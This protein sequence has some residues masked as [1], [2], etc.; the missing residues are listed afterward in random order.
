MAI[1]EPRDLSANGNHT[2]PDL[3]L[4]LNGRQ[5]LVDV[6]IRHPPC[7]TNIGHGA[8]RQQLAA[9]HQGET[10]KKA[11]YA[12]MA[13]A[14]QACFIPFSVETYGGLGK[15]AR[16]LIKVIASSAQEQLYMMDEEEVRKELKGSVAVAIQKGNARI[17][18]TEHYRA[19][20]AA[21]RSGRGQSVF[22]A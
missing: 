4:L 10:E 6:T 8:A 13:K 22:A 9:A 2:R 11:K 17:L 1:K 15:S 21:A 7:K 3:Q 18:L 5:Y 19:V 14:Q 12:A 16:K 20:S